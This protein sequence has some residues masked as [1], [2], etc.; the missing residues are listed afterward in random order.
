MNTLEILSETPEYYH[1]YVKLVSGEDIEKELEK[2]KIFSQDFFSKIPIEKYDYAY[3][4]GKWTIKAVLQHITD[5][6]RVFAYRALRF[7]RFDKTALP[8]FDENLFA[9]SARQMKTSIQFLIDEYLNVR[10]STI[11]L[12][13]NM[14]EEM[15]VCKGNANGHFFSTR[16]LAFI[17]IGHNMHHCNIINERYLNI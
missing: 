8:G 3:S 1:T 9:D 16:S 5:C 12:F 4:T 6:E 7:S 14:T 13:K 17:I 11:D 15:L 2:S 10:N